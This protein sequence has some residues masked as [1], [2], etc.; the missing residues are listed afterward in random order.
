[1]TF[2]DVP[3]MQSNGLINLASSVGDFDRLAGITRY[4]PG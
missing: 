4:G 3:S 1:M 2:A